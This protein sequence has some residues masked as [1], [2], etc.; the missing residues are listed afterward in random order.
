MLQVIETTMPLETIVQS[1]ARTECLL[2]AS[3][4]VQYLKHP[5]CWR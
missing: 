3:L 4:L 5:A 1:T 2:S